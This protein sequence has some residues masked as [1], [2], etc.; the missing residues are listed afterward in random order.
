MSYM[1]GLKLGYLSQQSKKSVLTHFEMVNI[2]LF[3][4]SSR[5]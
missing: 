4:M 3:F 5:S 1:C 2:G